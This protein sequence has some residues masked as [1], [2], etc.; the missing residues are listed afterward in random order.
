VSVPPFVGR[1][2]ELAYLRRELSAGRSVV[3]TGPYGIGRTSLLRHAAVEMARDWA[4]VFA[5]FDRSPG[6][7]WR[8]LYAAIF[9]RACKR[10]RGEVKSV[11]W[12]RFR[13]LNQRAEGRRPHVVV[14][15]NVA[16]LPAPRLDFVRRLREAYRVVAI[17]EDFLPE[18]AK[19]ALCSALWARP[20]LR[21]PHLSPAATVAYFEGCCRCHGFGWGPGEIEGLAQAVSGFPLGMREAVEAELRRRKARASGGAPLARAV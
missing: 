15:D 14:L 11:K 18:E 20:P 12:T 13:V 10:L 6:D 4:F 17:V 19:A 2:R 8:E 3:L 21:L 16:R 1:E 7:A 9:P 5:D